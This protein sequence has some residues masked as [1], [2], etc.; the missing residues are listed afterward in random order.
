MQY[1]DFQS[2]RCENACTYLTMLLVLLLLQYKGKCTSTSQLRVIIIN[3]YDGCLN[4]LIT[5]IRKQLILKGQTLHR[6]SRVITRR[7][8]ATAM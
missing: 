1:T 4:G 2:K 3:K 7:S 6:A 5:T 8:P